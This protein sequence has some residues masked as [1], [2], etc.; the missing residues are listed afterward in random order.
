VNTIQELYHLFYRG[1]V[2]EKL[3]LARRIWGRFGPQLRE[4]GGIVSGLDTVMEKGVVLSACMDGMGMARICSGCAAREG[5]GCCSLFMAGENDVLQLVMN[6]L[7]GVPVET[8]CTDGIHCCF[9]GERGCV[10]TL[11]PMF[12]LNY[13]C[14]EIHKQGAGE[15]IRLL[16]KVAGD[17]L[18]SQHALEQLLLM[19][20]QGR[21]G[22]LAQVAQEIR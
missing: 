19:F 2:Y 6:M 1:D 7:A 15:P 3:G 16:E 5:G 4:N 18:Q 13:N 10:L 14:R 11:K 22:Q 9:L 8:V 12:C 21:Q 20:F 17:L